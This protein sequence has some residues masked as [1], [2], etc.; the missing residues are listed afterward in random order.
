MINRIDNI[1]PLNNIKKL[2]KKENIENVDFSDFLKKA[3]YDT[4]NAKKYQEEL[5]NKLISGELNSMHE[6]SMARGIANVKFQALTEGIT[7]V[8]EA[9]KEISRIQI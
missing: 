1:I 8:V 9:Y 2:E 4:N 6:L 3:I 5:T 7:K